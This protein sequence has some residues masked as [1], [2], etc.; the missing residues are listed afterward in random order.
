MMTA[1]RSGSTQLCDY[2][3]DDTENFISSTVAETSFPYM[4]VWKLF[5]PILVKLGVD[6][7]QFHLFGAEANKRHTFVMLRTDAIDRIGIANFI[8]V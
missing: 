4:W 1:F 6:K 3:Q 8:L 5:V 2:L 7:M